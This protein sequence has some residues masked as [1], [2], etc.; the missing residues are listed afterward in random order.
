M[1]QVVINKTDIGHTFMVSK[2][3]SNDTINYAGTP[4]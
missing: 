3:T 4:L 1:E 2:L